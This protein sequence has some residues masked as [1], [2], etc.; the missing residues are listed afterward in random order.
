[1]ITMELR[2]LKPTFLLVAISCWLALTSSTAVNGDSPPP[3]WSNT[4]TVEG[5]VRIPYAE[6]EEPFTAYVDLNYGRS[7]IDYYGGVD[8]TFQLRDLGPH[9]SLVKLVPMTTEKVTNEINCFQANG[10][11]AEDAV[12]AQSVLPDMTGYEFKGKAMIDGT[13]C[14]KWQKVE[15]VEGKVNKYTMWLYTVTSRIDPRLKMAVPVKFQMKGYNILLGSHY[16]HY[17]ITYMGFSAEPPAAEVFDAYKS[18][19]CH[20]FPGPGDQVH[21]V[22][23]FNPMKEFVDGHEEHVDVA[24]DQFVRRHQKNYRDESDFQVRKD[25]FRQ[26]MRLIHS[27]NRKHLSYSLASNHL[28]DMT[29]DEMRVRRG[30]LRSSGSGYNGGLAFSYTQRDLNSVPATL[31][32]R[33]YGAVTPVKDQ[34]ICGSCWSF[35]TVGALEGAN[36]LAT[37]NLV[38]LSQQALVDCS[39]GY[40]NNACDGGED[41]RAYQWV[42]RHGGIPTEDS[43]GGYLGIDGFCHIDDPNVVTGFAMESYVN[44]TSGDA[45][46]LKVALSKHGPVSVAIDASHKTFSFYSN[47][48]YYEPDCH[49]D[50]EGLDHAVLAVGYGN[51]NG[52][53]Y[54]LIKNSWSTYWGNDGY[55]LMS[56][57][58]NNC[59]VATM[60]TFVNPKTNN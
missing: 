16:D 48:V 30:K 38:R 41:F 52:Q 7:R 54:W 37:G 8:K 13:Q 42:M 28:A 35:G 19:P 60:P 25:L 3:R 53:D 33:L 46:A 21:N 31:D 32:W 15:N 50:P 1:M 10:T 39:W 23:S 57:K 56:Q 22:Y 2:R 11:S 6:I 47:G 59:G 43:Y 34:A 49:S 51:I 26:N 9:G 40:G 4:Y 24:F 5:I 45:D 44:V 55:V 20:G 12:E 29:D 18:R 14:E 27:V 58:N 17:Y 36:F